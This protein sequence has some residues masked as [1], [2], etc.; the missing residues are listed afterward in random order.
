MIV[1]KKGHVIYWCVVAVT[2]ILL[3]GSGYMLFIKGSSEES[4]Q[5]IALEDAMDDGTEES[6]EDLAYRM[7]KYE[8]QALA[9]AREELQAMQ[10]GNLTEEDVLNALSEKKEIMQDYASEISET[11]PR[12]ESYILMLYY[13]SYLQGFWSE[14][15]DSEI[16]TDLHNN[17]LINAA[18]EMH[19]YLVDLSNGGEKSEEEESTI[20][21]LWEEI[22]DEDIEELVSLLFENIN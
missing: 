11:D 7:Y 2:V 3:L 12:K 8:E 1:M 14:N 22:T 9:D 18:V 13:S 17:A 5:Q 21:K 16:E 4:S 10:E 15:S 6:S 20:E 19:N